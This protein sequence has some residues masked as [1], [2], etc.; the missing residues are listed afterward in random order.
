MPIAFTLAALV[1]VV[2][3]LVGKP[4]ESGIGL[5]LVM[6]GVPIYYA[7]NRWRGAVGS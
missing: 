3:T 6:A 2:A 5:A 1:I 4:M 7:W